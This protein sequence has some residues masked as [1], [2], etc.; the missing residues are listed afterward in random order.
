MGLQAKIINL[1]RFSKY[2][3]LIS[4]D[5]TIAL[6][7]T[8]I[9][10]FLRIELRRLPREEEIYAY[11]AAVVLAILIFYMMGVYKNIH[12]YGAIKY[13]SNLLRVVTIYTAAYAS[14]LWAFSFQNVPRSIALIQPIV[15]FT[16]FYIS[17]VAAYDFLSK[18]RGAVT[19]A[20]RVLIYGAGEVGVGLAITLERSRQVQ[21]VGFLDDDP[22]KI[23]KTINGISVTP[24]ADVAHAI[25]E[26]TA[27][28][29]IV[30]ISETHKARRV[31]V[32]K[33]LAG[34]GVRVQ[35]A[36]DVLDVGDG[37][38]RRFVRAELNVADLLLRDPIAP[39]TDT[40][41]YIKDRV[42]L[43]SGAGGSIGGELCRQV[44]MKGAAHLILVEHSEFGLYEIEKELANLCR[45]EGHATK[46]TPVLMSIRDERHLSDL[47]QKHR[48]DI[49]Y[50]AAA[51]KHV[52]LVEANPCEA[53]ANNIIGTANMI[54]ASEAAGVKRF[55]LI[56]TDKAVRPTNVMGAS[57]RVAELLV[58]GRH[59][60]GTSNT[61][62]SMVRFGNVLGSSGS[63]VPL[64]REQIAQGGPVTVTHAEVT[65]FFMT[66]PEAV[67]LVLEAAQVAEG[68]E[69]FL[70]DMGEPVKIIDLARTMIGLAGHTV[71]DEANPGGEIEIVEVGLRPGEKMYEE[72]LISDN[73]LPTANRHIYMARETSLAPDELRRQYAAITAMIESRRDE[74]LRN[75]LIK[76]AN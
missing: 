52:P 70:L 40:S 23:G 69:V 10:F 26:A 14:V 37:S 46:L 8:Y 39:S 35:T 50:H 5:A 55:M 9:A 58:Q 71:R 54:S 38:I 33:R 2:A 73:P 59:E 67:G 53:A 64:F 18:S 43:V 48:P 22:K 75:T 20:R 66:I 32:I 65:R 16:L 7:S 30:A 15:F 49:V 3:I 61:I 68:G 42:I 76:L 27:S 45:T 11:I 62:Y 31:A 28:D 1:S 57:K 44:V 47:F 12:R 41:A 21:V 36:K 24:G 17:R 60:A 19:E 51:Y 25:K 56:S 72:L 74:E 34:L 6:I 4:V 63:V 29:V 13:D